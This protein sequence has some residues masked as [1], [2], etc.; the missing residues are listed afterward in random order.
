MNMEAI[1]RPT[2]VVCSR[3]APGGPAGASVVVDERI[4]TMRLPRSKHPITGGRGLDRAEWTSP[5]FFWGSTQTFYI[6]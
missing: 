6:L 5:L 1:V 2:L 4:P 3:V